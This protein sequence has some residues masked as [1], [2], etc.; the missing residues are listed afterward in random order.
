MTLERINPDGLS[1]PE[2]YTQV[3]VAAGSRLVFVA[4]QVAEDE[5]GN[6]VGR[7]D[8]PT[9]ARQAFSNLARALAA[10]GA[11]PEHVA[12]LGIFVVALHED[13]LPGIEAARVALFG[14]HKPVDTLLGVEKLAHRG[15][16]LEVDAIAV[17][18]S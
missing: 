13:H 18:G 5:D 12:R 9:Q 17:I 1:R 10:A 16:L 15:C 6:V 4:G 2:T 14:D 11:S 7:G 8:V 3:V